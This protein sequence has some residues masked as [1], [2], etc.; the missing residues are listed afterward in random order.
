MIN[1][2]VFRFIMAILVLMAGLQYSLAEEADVYK[3][4][5]KIMQEAIQT[6]QQEM[7]N[8]SAEKPP[9][10]KLKDAVDDLEWQMNT[11]RQRSSEH[12]IRPPDLR[13]I[14]QLCVN[15]KGGSGAGEQTI[16]E[17]EAKLQEIKKSRDL[18]EKVFKKMKVKRFIKYVSAE[19]DA[20]L[21]V[22][23]TPTGMT[24]V[25]LVDKVVSAVTGSV[26]QKDPAVVG[27]F[28]KESDPATAGSNEEAVK[29]KVQDWCS[30]K[31]K[32]EKGFCTD[33][34]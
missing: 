11:L 12:S 30:D 20:L 13:A 31:E 4:Y 5:E 10:N 24:I 16:K 17:K 3:N 19:V 23:A 18:A 29:R 32:K 27:K 8:I 28:L 33:K 22:L 25:D 2:K 1:K 7:S 26:A 9:S 21:S 14:L 15:I 34:R 6:I